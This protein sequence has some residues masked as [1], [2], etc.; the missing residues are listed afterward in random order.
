[1]E[2]TNQVTLERINSIKDRNPGFKPIF[3]DSLNKLPGHDERQFIITEGGKLPFLEGNKSHFAMPGEF[4]EMK[5]RRGGSSKFLEDCASC[6]PGRAKVEFAA[7][8]LCE[9]MSLEYGGDEYPMYYCINSLLP[10]LVIDG[11]AYFANDVDRN[12][13]YEFYP[14]N[15]KMYYG[16]PYEKAW[17]MAKADCN[18]KKP[19]KVGK[20]TAHKLILWVEYCDAYE[21]FIGERMDA[22]QKKLR[23]FKLSYKR[24]TGKDFISNNSTIRKNHFEL[25]AG[26]Y[27]SG[28]VYSG[29]RETYGN[30]CIKE[31][32]KDIKKAVNLLYALE[33]TVKRY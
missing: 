20:P 15:E 10:C 14:C 16:E 7:E 4:L 30:S 11:K 8:V 26:I 19:N 29:V 22:F 23:A 12:G 25:Y 32:G 1:M 13:K 2:I 5:K 3:T 18:I 27:S 24:A 33:D 31:Y 21:K 9:N 6:L 28:E 17:L